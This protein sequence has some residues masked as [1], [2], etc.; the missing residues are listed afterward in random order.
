MRTN[1]EDT[2][3]KAG[4]EVTLCGWLATK[5]DHGKIMFLDLR[6]R[7]GTIQVVV[8]RNNE[9]YD[10]VALTK[11]ESTLKITG[12][13]KERPENLVNK[14]MPTGAIELSAS[15]IEILSKAD[16]VPFAIDE[17]K[18]KVSEDVRLKYRYLDL[19]RKKM[20]DNIVLRSKVIKFIRDYLADK[21]FIDIETPNLGKS[22]PEGARDYLVPSRQQQGKFYALPQSPQQYKQLLMVAGFEKYYQI[23]RCFRDEDT[24]GDR[25]AEFTQLDLEMSFIENEE[26]LL[27]LIEELFIA[28]VEKLTPE[29]HISQIPFPRIKYDVAMEQYQSDKPDLRKKKDDDNE[30]AFAFVTDFPMFEKSKDTG[31]WTAVHHPFTMPQTDNI[32]AIKNNPETVKAKQYDFVLNGYE[33][34]GGSIRTHKPEILEAVFEVLGHSKE[35]IRAQFGHLLQAFKYGV[36]PHG[37]IAPGLDRIVMLL[38]GEPNIREVIAF[39]KTGDGRD[40]MMEAPSPVDATQLDDLSLKILDKTPKNDTVVE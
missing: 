39:P 17:N 27:S 29:K 20:H 30:L 37:G 3:D 1:I 34:A 35:Q 21:G 10:E 13:V 6:D 2:V 18:S 32:D 5:R 26:E 22:T 11:V 9:K 12:T 25:Q 19:R 14:E 15:V 40:L 8:E 38:A 16:D 36:P 31:R 7:T 23:A 33:I 4:E 28:L 24:R